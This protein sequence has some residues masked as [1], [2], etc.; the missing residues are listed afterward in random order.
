MAKNPRKIPA[1]SIVSA[2]VRV[3]PEGHPDIKYYDPNKIIIVPN[4]GS[5]LK[6]FTSSPFDAAVS[7]P[8]SD[9]VFIDPEKDKPESKSGPETIEKLD[10]VDL[11]SIE[12]VTKEP[13]Y[14]PVTKEL[15]YKVIIKIR[16][17]SF[18]KKSVKGVDARIKPE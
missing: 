10:I 7:L 14:D 1:D 17:T 11:S 12:K 9:D 8:D 3:L 2:G 4:D 16:N 5:K 6:F 18:R 15:K 13:Y